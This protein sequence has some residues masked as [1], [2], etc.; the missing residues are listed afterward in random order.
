MKK[1]EKEAEKTKRTE[2]ESKRSVEY[3][4]LI[5]RVAGYSAHFID[6]ADHTQ[7]SIIERT[8]FHLIRAKSTVGM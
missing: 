7:D 2:E 6:L 3:S 1:L 8:G 4:D 5:V